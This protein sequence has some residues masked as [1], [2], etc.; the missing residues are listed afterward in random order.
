[1]AQLVIQLRYDLEPWIALRLRE[2][3]DSGFL[4]AGEYRGN[5]RVRVPRV[6]KVT[7]RAAVVN[8]FDRVYLIRAGDVDVNTAS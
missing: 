4:S 5:T 6:G 3:A 7:C 2:S 8:L 1:M